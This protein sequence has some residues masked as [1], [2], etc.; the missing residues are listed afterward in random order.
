MKKLISN[1]KFLALLGLMMSVFVACEDDD[2][3]YFSADLI[4]GEW[5]TSSVEVTSI[6]LNGL[7]FIDVMT[8]ALGAQEAAVFEAQMEAEITDEMPVA[9]EFFEDGS[10]LV[11]F[12]GDDFSVGT[13]VLEN[14]VLTLDEGTEDETVLD[15]EKLTSGSLTVVFAESD[16]DDFDGDG[17]DDT[18]SLEVELSMTK[19]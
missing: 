13:W 4:V 12:E 10:Y 9:I 17:E 6:K 14:N 1:L 5:T 8:L 11:E 16:D 3:E 18:L 2:E 19:I 7:D 15:V